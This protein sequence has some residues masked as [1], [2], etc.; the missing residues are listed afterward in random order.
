MNH[1]GLQNPW[2]DKRVGSEILTRFF[3]FKIVK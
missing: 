3:N 1:S 2:D